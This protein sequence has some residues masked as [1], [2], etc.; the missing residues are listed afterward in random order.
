MPAP[1]PPGRAAVVDAVRGAAILAMI[2]YHA[3][4]FATEE[5]FAQI[6][7]GAAGWRA[8]QRTVAGTFFLLVG[9]SVRLAGEN[10][11][12]FS[13]FAFRSAR[14]AGCAA[15]VSVTS[16][17]LDPGRFVTFGVLHCIFVSSM[18][19]WPLRRAGFSALPLALGWLVL[20]GL[21]GDPRFDTPLLRWTGLGS[22]G[23]PTFDFQP[24]VPW[25]GLVLL[26]VVAATVMPATLWTWRAKHS[27]PLG[28]LGRR[29]LFLYMAH[30][31]VLMGLSKSIR[32]CLLQSF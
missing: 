2:A 14:I 12:R 1:P 30:V 6:D 31:P 27:D 22:A 20:A 17:V 15:V 28:W 16:L 24:F 13:H 11:V 3:A 26:G 25:F 10:Q 9:V 19:A 5:G 18:L 23:V 29:S 21:P 32:W 4:W 7:F 8:Y